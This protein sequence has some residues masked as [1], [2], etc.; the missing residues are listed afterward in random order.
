MRLPWLPK[1]GSSA[2]VAHEQMGLESV[3]GPCVLRWR[4]QLLDFIHDAIHLSYRQVEWLIGG[5][6]FA[7]YC[8]GEGAKQRHGCG[9][10]RI[11]PANSQASHIPATLVDMGSRAVDGQTQNLHGGHECESL[12]L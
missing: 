10:C 9:R 6:P 5:T 3:C 7:F 11:E 4:E 12:L 2:S 1:L 8:P